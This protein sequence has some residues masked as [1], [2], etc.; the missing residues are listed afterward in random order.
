MR[1]LLA[2]SAIVLVIANNH[3]VE[4]LSCRS[5]FNT[6]V[7][8][9]PITFWD[10]SNQCSS[11]SQ[12]SCFLGEISYKISL[13]EDELAL[14]YGSCISSAYESLLSCDELF[15][16]NGLNVDRILLM[17]PDLQNQLN[18]VI[19]DFSERA[20]KE[21]MKFLQNEHGEF[22]NVKLTQSIF[23]GLNV[24]VPDNV[25]PV[26]EKIDSL[27]LTAVV[28]VSQVEKASDKLLT[29]FSNLSTPDAAASK[30]IY[31]LFRRN[32]VPVPDNYRPM[33]ENLP[34]F[35][36]QFFKDDPNYQ[37]INATLYTVLANIDVTNPI[38]SVQS[39]PQLLNSLVPSAYRLSP[40]FDSLSQLIDELAK[41][42]YDY[43]NTWGINVMKE[44]SRVTPATEALSNSTFDLL[45][46][47]GVNLTDDMITLI[48][49]QPGYFYNF[50]D[51]SDELDYIFLNISKAIDA[52]DPTAPPNTK[53]LLESF[54]VKVE[55]AGMDQVFSTIDGIIEVASTGNWMALGIYSLEALQE[56]STVTT[57]SLAM[58]NS[59]NSLLERSN[60]SL[61]KEVKDVITYLP[62][63]F[64]TA[65]QQDV[66]LI[67]SIYSNISVNLNNIDFTS[68]NYGK[69]LN[70]AL[71]PLLML[72]L[73]SEMTT[74]LEKIPSELNISD[75]VGTIKAVI[76]FVVPL[77]P[78]N[79]NATLPLL[80]GLP[81][82]INEMI[83]GN[84]N[85]INLWQADA[86]KAVSTTT[87][88]T[89]M[90]NNAIVDMSKR[91][92]FEDNMTRETKDL[93]GLQL[94]IFYTT[95]PE[96]QDEVNSAINVV[97]AIVEATDL[98]KLPD[99]GN[100]ISLLPGGDSL[101]VMN[102][103]AA[104]MKEIFDP[105]NVPGIDNPTNEPPT[106]SPSSFNFTTI[107]EAILQQLKDI[108]VTLPAEVHSEI[109]KLPSKI[110]VSDPVGSLG[111]AIN[112]ISSLLPPDIKP[113]VM[114]VLNTLPEL[115]NQLL[116]NN[117]EYLY[118]TWQLELLKS[119]SRITA[120]TEE[121]RNS[122]FELLKRYGVYDNI[123]NDMKTYITYQ[124]G[125][126]YLF[127]P[128]ESH[129]TLEYTYKNLSAI[130]DLIDPTSPPDLR[131]IF[132]LLSPVADFTVI[133]QI[134]PTLQGFINAAM[135]GN[136]TKIRIYSIEALKNTSKSTTESLQFSNSIIS[137]LE[138]M[139]VLLS[140]EV[141][142]IIMYLPGIFTASLHDN[143]A[144]INAIFANVSQ[145][146]SNSFITTPED[147]DAAIQ[148]TIQQ[149]GMLNLTLPPPVLYILNEIPSKINFSDP[150]SSL[151][152]AV[153]VL[154]TLIP[155]EM[156]I[157]IPMMN[158][159]PELINQLTQ[160][161]F[162]YLNTWQLE[163]LKTASKI[164]P[165]TEQLSNAI[166]NLT[167]RFGVYE[168]LTDD[169]K[170][171]ITYQ[172]G[173][174]YLFAQENP[175]VLDMLLRNMSLIIDNINLSKTP[176][177]MSILSE[178]ISPD[179]LY[180][181]VSQATASIKRFID[182]I[183]SN[184][185]WVDSLL[186]SSIGALQN[187]STITTE[188]I[189]LSN[190]IVNLL[191]R[192]N[193]TV[194]SDIN[195]VIKYFPGLFVNMFQDN[196]TLI[197]SF[198]ANI[199]QSLDAIN[200]TTLRQPITFLPKFIS[201]IMDGMPL[202]EAFVQSIGETLYTE[203]ELT[204]ESLDLTNSIVQYFEKMNVTLDDF[205]KD[206]LKHIPGIFVTLFPDNVTLVNEIYSNITKNLNAVNLTH[207]DWST[208]LESTIQQ[209]EMMN[210]S[211][212]DE[213]KT[214]LQN[215]ASRINMS[216]PIGS[217]RLTI[218]AVVLI[219]PAEVQSIV[220]TLQSI[221]NLLDQL[222][223]G[224]F[225]Y[226]TS[227]QLELLKS[228]S[229]ITPATQMLSNSVYEMTKRFGIYNNLT[230]DLRTLIDYQPGYLYMFFVG[231]EN[232]L[233]I[234]YSNISAII[235]S[236]N[237]TNT[238]DLMSLLGSEGFNSNLTEIEYIV[239]VTE[240]L[241]KATTSG[242][243]N[244]ILN[245]LLQ[246]FT[247]L[248]IPSDES[249]DLSN[250]LLD[251]I[252]NVN[253]SLPQDVLDVI[254]NLPGF[255]IRIFPNETEVIN[256]VYERTAQ[257]I[258]DSMMSSGFN[259]EQIIKDTIQQLN[260]SGISIPGELNVILDN[261]P[262]L[263]D[264]VTKGDTNRINKW[265]VEVISL[266]KT[267]STNSSITLINS[268][269][270]LLGQINGVDTSG[271]EVA[272]NYLVTLPYQLLEETNTQ[273]I[274]SVYDSISNNLV[275][276]NISAT[277][278]M[279]LENVNINQVI[280]DTMKLLNMNSTI[281]PNDVKTIIKLLPTLVDSL[282]KLNTYEI[283][284]WLVNVM[285]LLD[286][287]TTNASLALVSAVKH[288]LSQIDGVDTSGLEAALNYIT[289]LTYQLRPSQDTHTIDA[290]YNSIADSLININLT[291]FD[292][293]TPSNFN[294]EQVIKDTIEQ[295]SLSGVVIPVDVRIIVNNLP[296]LFNAA[297]TNNTEAINAWLVEIMS[298]LNTP[299]TNASITLVNAVKHVL[300]QLD[301]V[302]TSGLEAAL[303]YIVTLP[304]QLLAGNNSQTI[305]T[306]YDS[307]T[308]SLMNINL[309]ATEFNPSSLSE[310]F[311]QLDT[312]F[313][314][315]EL[316]PLLKSSEILIM[317]ATTMNET[318]FMQ[319]SSYIHTHYCSSNDVTKSFAQTISTMLSE[320]GISVPGSAQ[321]GLECVPGSL[322]AALP[323][324]AALITDV[325]NQMTLAFTNYS[326]YIE[327]QFSQLNVSV[328][329]ELTV[330]INK[331]PKIQ[332]ALA[333]NNMS[334]IIQLLI[335]LQQDM[336]KE[337]ELSK[338]IVTILTKAGVNV[339]DQISM[340][341]RQASTS[342][343][344][345]S[346]P[347]VHPTLDTIFSSLNEDIAANK[348]IGVAIQD[349]FAKANVT[350]Y[351]RLIPVL[352]NVQS[353]I[354]A[355]TINDVQGINDAILN[356]LVSYN[357]SFPSDQ[358]QLSIYTYKFQ[359]ALMNNMDMLKTSLPD[360]A[361][362]Q[363]VNVY[364][365]ILKS[366]NVTGTD[367][368]NRLLQLFP[369]GRPII[370]I[371]F[372]LDP[373][374]A[375]SSMSNFVYWIFDPERTTTTLASYINSTIHLL[376]DKHGVNVAQLLKTLVEPKSCSYE[377]CKTDNC[378]VRDILP[379]HTTST[380]SSSVESTGPFT[381]TSPNSLTDQA[382]TTSTIWS[383]P[384]TGTSNTTDTTTFSGG[385]INLHNAASLTL[386][387]SS[388]LFSITSFDI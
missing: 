339:T 165:A 78:V 374:Q 285:G 203:A 173:Y 107:V 337:T 235:D 295:I 320:Y 223:Q 196:I 201:N 221:P 190:S 76:D 29:S 298:L 364:Q 355:A 192:M 218:E 157:T 371:F 351:D 327:G 185:T 109:S 44:Y 160:G 205:A 208:P 99:I 36:I 96:S 85:Y 254:S 226:I 338:L 142:E 206:A 110:N 222:I 55:L 111:M 151:Q 131:S 230:S 329:F 58:S 103:F 340:S 272:L 293:M 135:T 288:V 89:K 315:A 137:L 224:N 39:V 182:G 43:L 342:A 5:G 262:A 171:A 204:Q 67:N 106:F 74:I 217:L 35:I 59:I 70:S 291:A 42:N 158:T 149:L 275:K 27:L 184:K 51:Y 294:I 176:D 17:L 322:Y 209:L 24:T 25:K 12:Q 366:V 153:D 15:G 325:F 187:S 104:S 115:L 1:L 335:E 154:E 358:V 314:P 134:I 365:L 227:W 97:T 343:Y 252:G 302:E 122:I 312:S 22:D 156:N 242:N 261:V 324:Q 40:L 128:P 258:R 210:I 193:V 169:M 86:L 319:W 126:F 207:P 41:E 87:N 81:D 375:F 274:D 90:L 100:I 330:L 264:A 198:F 310:M 188:S 141:K 280:E 34:G 277:N 352:N 168:N 282:T 164:T 123:T 362:E 305:D 386:F 130:L 2:V 4:G 260:A 163:L 202:L 113:I 127:I 179:I 62:G 309:T 257:S 195:N 236:I 290:V 145:G 199:S 268:V 239:E 20:A 23:H 380:T 191:Q 50:V 384:V 318:L 253:V 229:R 121:L 54:G 144:M 234:A 112:S 93:I 189:A 359:L 71:S 286:T 77:I 178:I 360:E 53:S 271:L 255:F 311:E 316:T 211:I 146:I 387:F 66:D 323:D 300:G 167:M 28:N 161:N 219:L 143:E 98:T 155:P 240:Q 48:K 101:D 376:L 267:P 367:L 279:N 313:L 265:L 95:H 63:L 347:Q 278:L 263:F 32:G 186:I 102:Q 132:N 266:L 353:L 251:F 385:V 150:I 238:L 19:D 369:D 68:P 80:R 332:T 370:E 336:A 345:P 47:F 220:P 118:T 283:N 354:D 91:F 49:Y 233:E 120:T 69:M 287:P 16:T 250:T 273:T 341:I 37:N 46:R 13:I 177:L 6:S 79:M 139:G 26:L 269:K 114:P 147:L 136:A 33:I 57:Q 231:N 281:I 125:Y 117:V 304:Y 256:I 328:P 357:A 331:L 83:K 334:Q 276:I 194:N 180:P 382:L 18:V 170:T 200:T 64:I 333:Q 72:N 368:R 372:Q 299:S 88:E 306:V 373:K 326:G 45:K 82:L 245:T 307:I 378:N 292:S 216:D 60:I 84:Y 321:L 361:F 73:T 9:I 232:D 388:V 148:S 108:N 308:N 138:R 237:S 14:T 317:A 92:G 270:Y 94:G 244:I 175:D 30:L 166:F 116:Q 381:S 183:I 303:K 259:I 21:V 383:E 297:T 140:K 296:A 11:A 119:V 129:V 181:E 65:F 56:S 248:S 10:E 349:A 213:I 348:D 356:I 346:W 243:I 212:P 172:P 75:P 225:E 215:L 249:R 61:K 344:N 379:A 124:L 247:N 152:G 7:Y 350:M 174:F 38:A 284:I 228:Y 8:G 246:S 289:T 3:P 105:L 301:G 52:I 133:D 31:D 159:L 241:L 377:V 363:I 162:I 197:N 214:M